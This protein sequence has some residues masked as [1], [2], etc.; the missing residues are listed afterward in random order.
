[1]LNKVVVLA[2]LAVLL[3]ACPQPAVT[4]AVKGPVQ[5]ERAAECRASCTALGMEL[6]SVVLILNNAGCV[7]QV[8]GAQPQQ[9]GGA[10]AASGGAAIAVMMAQEEERKRD[11][12]K[13]Q[14]EEKEK[15][16]RDERDQREREEQQR[17]SL[18]E[19]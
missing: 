1:M 7:C 15:K 4:P 2:T 11:A 12:E 17:R 10:A 9:S 18:S 19:R 3:A 6:Q 14:Q 16:D 13:Q 8:L 5:V